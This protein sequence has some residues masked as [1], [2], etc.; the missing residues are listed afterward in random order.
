MADGV[1]GEEDGA[2][3]DGEEIDDAEDTALS[4]LLL[5]YIL[6]LKELIK[7]CR[8]NQGRAFI[9][10]FPNGESEKVLLGLIS[11][12]FIGSYFITRL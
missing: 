6:A 9:V 5:I 8:H 1:G 11:R 2:A 7:W 3:V 12:S 4:A 10:Q